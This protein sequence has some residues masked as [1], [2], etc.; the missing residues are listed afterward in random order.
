MRVDTAPLLENHRV[1]HSRDAEEARAFLSGKDFHLEIGSRDARDL[2]FRI[3]GIYL[4]GL[5]IGYIQYGPPTRVRA[6][7]AREDYW[8]Q[9]PLCGRL[10]VVGGR[11][12]VACDTRRAAVASPT[13]ADYYLVQS[14][15]G[16]AGLRLSLPRGS[17]NA[18][19]AGLL[20]EPPTAPIA[21]A[22]EMDL[23]SGYGERLA[24]HVRMAVADFEPPGPMPWGRVMTS[25]FEDFIAAELLLNH[26]SNYSEVLRRLETD[27]APRDVR[28]AHA[29]IEA[30]LEEPIT[31]ADI[32]RASGV[33]GRTL[34]K[35]FR[36]H[37]GM[38]PMRYLRNARFERARRAL[39]AAGS[40][41]SVTDIALSL[42][43]THLGRFSIEYRRRFGESPSQALRRG[44]WT[45]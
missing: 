45:T 40:E 44:R 41:D 21:F 6:G 8:I 31:I 43:F 27:I 3:N 30:N 32:A 19:L 12:V 36:D 35:H 38:T 13:R 2:D 18:Q 9:L 42:G 16:C 23:A 37:R 33:P 7:P 39:L 25:A 11:D 22:P 14:E 5:F 24:R 4:P 15:V 28:R 29:F 1:V 34:F 26:P 10:Q 17:L 20:G